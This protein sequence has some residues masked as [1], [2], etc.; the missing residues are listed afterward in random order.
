MSEKRQWVRVLGL[1]LIGISAGLRAVMDELDGRPI[2]L[3]QAPPFPPP[4]P[5]RRNY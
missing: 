2:V 5:A 1:A 4:D 3:Q